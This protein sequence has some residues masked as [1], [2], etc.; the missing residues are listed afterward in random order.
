MLEFFQKLLDTSDFPSRWNCGNWDSGH[1][2]LHIISDSLIFGAYLTIPLALFAVAWKKHRELLF[3]KLVLLFALFILCCGIGHFIEATIFWTPWYRL[4]GLS[5]AITA[6]IS[7]ITAIVAI[8][9]L[10]EILKLPGIASLNRDLEYALGREKAMISELERSNRDLDEFAYAASHDLRAPLRS[11]RN[12]ASWIEED[13]GG[14]LPEENRRHLEQLQQRAKRLDSLLENLLA[15]SRAGRNLESPRPVDLNEV[16]TRVIADLEPS[17]PEMTF[18]IVN[19]LPVISTHEIPW[20]Q[21]FMNL[22][23]NAIKHQSTP[24]D[25]VEISSSSHGRWLK[26]TVSDNGPGIDPDHFDRIF[27]MFETLQSKDTTEGSGIGLALVQKLVSR[28]GGTIEVES[29]VG[30]GSKFTVAIPS[31]SV[32]EN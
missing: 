2:W 10:P 12:L 7:W 5:K 8:R 24:T 3:E 27:R 26:V 11:I 19:E 30:S 28:M 13:S 32:I 1:G 23:S 4:S 29:E 17:A 15:Y 21:I 18:R 25:T 31:D 14:I 22:I 20:E 16:L 6:T 9:K